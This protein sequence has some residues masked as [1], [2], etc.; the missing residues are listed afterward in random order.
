MTAAAPTRPPRGGAGARLRRAPA[1]LG[2]RLRRAA[3]RLR[4][5][6][7]RSG[8]WLVF[9]AATLVALVHALDDAFVHRGP[10]LG[11][12]ELVL[13]AAVALGAALAGVLAFP[14]LRPGVKAALALCFGVLAG[15][16]GA[17]HLNHVR[18]DGPAGADV[19][20]V[21]A[22][23]AGVVLLGLAAAIPWRHRGERPARRRLD[24]GARRPGAAAPGR[25][26]RPRPR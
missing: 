13:A 10:G 7:R 26:L 16:N 22:L 20:G 23:A 15:V 2:L 8:E 18:A 1:T 9:T 19:T 5:G 6:G 14:F 17:M 3:P 25:R 4:T 12:G 24:A 11:A 21:L